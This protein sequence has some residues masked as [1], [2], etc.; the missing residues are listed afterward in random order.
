[1]CDIGPVQL[2][3]DADMSDAEANT[4]TV[5]FVLAAGSDTEHAHLYRMALGRCM[6]LMAHNRV[7]GYVN[8]LIAGGVNTD[9]G[10]QARQV[11]K[12]ITNMAKSCTA[13]KRSKDRYLFQ[14]VRTRLTAARLAQ[15]V[16]LEN[17]M[18]AIAAQL[19]HRDTNKTVGRYITEDIGR[20]CTVS[21]WK[22]TTSIEIFTIAVSV[23]QE[24][25]DTEVSLLPL[26]FPLLF[27]F[28]P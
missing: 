24:V 2:A 19:D 15:L 9:H 18:G 5:A 21:D 4:C 7:H 26:L 3:M 10:I 16:Y 25:L 11:A 12:I 14:Q 17:P 6:A 8:K 13:W 22:T 27:D 23:M 28:V 20:L 1:M